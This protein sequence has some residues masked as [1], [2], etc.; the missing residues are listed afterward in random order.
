MA[1]KYLLIII[2]IA[3]ISSCAQIG[4][5]TGGDKDTN[6]PIPDLANSNP[7]NRSVNFDGKS[8]E[9]SFD[10]F[11]KLN[12]PAQ[13]IKMVPP[14]AS[15][16][17][18]V[19]GKSLILKWEDSLRVNTTYAIYLNQAVKDVTEGNDSLIQFVFSTG[20]Q[21]DSLSYTCH[22]IDAV[23]YSPVENSLVALFDPSNGEVINVI[24][25][26]KEGLAELRYI[27]PG[28]YMI[29]AF[30]DDNQNLKIDKNE[31]VG[32]KDEDLVRIDSSI[33]D[34]IPFRLFTPRPKPAIR[35]AKFIAP[36]SFIIGT[37]VV[38]I[39]P[40]FFYN[41]ERIDSFNIRT[42]VRDSFQLFLPVDKINSGTIKMDAENYSDSVKLLVL[43]SQKQKA[44]N[45]RSMLLNNQLKPNGIINLEA[46]DL[47]TAIDTSRIK[48]LNLPDSSL[49]EIEYLSIDK[50]FFHF[51]VK[52]RLTEKVIISIPKGSVIFQNGVNES[53]EAEYTLNQ[54]KKFGSL[55][56]V[57]PQYD[58]I[59][60]IRILSAGKI[61]DEKRLVT[62]TDK[63]EFKYLNPGDYTF[64]V[65]LDVNNNGYWDTGDLES[66][67]QPESI[68]HFP[69]PVKV[70][71]NWEISTTL[72][73][74]GQR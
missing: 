57:A 12:N 56:V 31:R 58:S 13:T 70:R 41:G 28:E 62:G 22:V 71:A 32:F 64:E 59:G 14:H 42:Y 43:D 60:I 20:S 3:L 34:S 29:Q 37:S 45:L 65:L 63:V 26:G 49:N 46:N 2:S 33:Y 68:D 25:S 9:I 47:I 21:L 1:G 36:G 5:L 16:D 44:I 69:E 19:K 35:T 40:E 7:P 10:E 52:N 72:T 51:Q 50:N 6:A 38:P 23:S 54:E 18:E 74:V 11:I 55:I 61:V 24:N 15:I 4:S 73:P 53:F 30:I 66:K 39:N 48:I 17:A 67:L 8:I 27:H